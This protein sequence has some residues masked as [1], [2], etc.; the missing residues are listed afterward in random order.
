MTLKP[1][2]EDFI[3]F[4]YDIPPYWYNDPPPWYFKLPSETSQTKPDVKPPSVQEASVHNPPMGTPSGPP[5]NTNVQ[6]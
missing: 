4:W 3:P 6:Y 2:Q 5:V 1:T